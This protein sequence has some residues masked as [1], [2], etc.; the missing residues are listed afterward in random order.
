MAAALVILVWL[1]NYGI[2]V[3]NAYAVG[4]AWVETK[5][6]GGWPRFMAW[7][8]AIMSASGFSWCYLI[9][10]AFAAQGLGWLELEHITFALRLGYVLLIP[11]ILFSGMMIMLNSWAK[12]YRTRKV[13]DVGVAAWNTYAQIHNSYHA[14]DS[15]GEALGGIVEALSKGS[16]S[17]NDKKGGAVAVILVFILVILALLS[18]VITTALIIRRVAG[19]DQLKEPRP[20][21][22]MKF[23]QR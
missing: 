3:W 1:L 6:S 12:A 21:E 14:I 9:V 19:N 4:V 8:G 5:H 18:G 15:L 20:E 7:M 13:G 17:R 2:S 10:L 23:A 22:E 16:S 11:G